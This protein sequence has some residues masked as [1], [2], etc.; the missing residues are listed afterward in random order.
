MKKFFL[1]ILLFCIV[2]VLYS[3]ES[4]GY[5]KFRLGM[6]KSEIMD[7]VYN[8]YQGWGLY[9]DQGDV[10]AKKTFYTLKRSDSYIINFG[11][12]LDNL[13]SVSIYEMFD[14]AKSAKNE[15]KRLVGILT[16]KYG[17]VVCKTNHG[18]GK[19]TGIIT[20]WAQG[21]HQYITLQ[22]ICLSDRDD[23]HYCLEYWDGRYSSSIVSRIKKQKYDDS[24][25]Y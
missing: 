6:N 2:P 4:I 25:K 17:K 15:Y 5:D 8:N 22:V 9:K 19:D 13:S 10:N 11:F 1:V 12:Y 14:D 18:T 3:Q 23:Y 16:K 24:Y 7:I 21:D 20:E